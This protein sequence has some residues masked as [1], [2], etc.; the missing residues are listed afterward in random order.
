MLLSFN[1]LETLNTQKGDKMMNTERNRNDKIIDILR[2]VRTDNYDS[3]GYEMI[4]TPE[5]IYQSLSNFL[6]SISDDYFTR[7]KVHNIERLPEGHIC[8]TLE[9]NTNKALLGVILGEDFANFSYTHR[10]EVIMEIEA[11]SVELLVLEN[12]FNEAV[13]LF[14]ENILLTK[15]KKLANTS[16]PQTHN[17][18]WPTTNV[19][20][21]EPQMIC[22]RV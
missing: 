12:S 15:K 3:Q 4:S 13:N 11:Q 10:W 8:V 2:K 1:L 16:K 21:L 20:E 22:S 14:I 5:K 19:V 7:L 18:V 9:D 17:S 6:L